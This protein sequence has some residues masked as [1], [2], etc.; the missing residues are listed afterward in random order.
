MKGLFLTFVLTFIFGL[1]AVSQGT[2]SY[3]SCD[4]EAVHP[5]SPAPCSIA[6]T[7]VQ[8]T[9]FMIQVGSYLNWVNP[10]PGTI[11]MQ[12]LLDDG[13]LLHRYYIAA[14]FPSDQEA[15]AFL[16]SKRVKEPTTSGGMGY[17]DAQVVPYPFAGVIGYR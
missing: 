11:M 5:Y 14:I 12:F 7:G 8:T 13:R 3:L 6:G 15:Q 10:K 16:T 2:V 1:T 9:L 17:C 4:P